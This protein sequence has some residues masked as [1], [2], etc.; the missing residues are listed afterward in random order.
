MAGALTV[1]EL[2][3]RY[4]FKADPDPIKRMDAAV[5]KLK[6]GVGLLDRGVRRAFS[7]VATAS[8]V[9]VAAFGA[10]AVKMVGDMDQVA[11]TSKRLGVSSQF[12][13]GMAHAAEL[14]GASVGELTTSL[15]RISAAAND[16]ASGSKTTKEAFEEIGVSVKDASGNLKPME[17]LTLETLEGL[18][19]LTDKTKQAALAQR[20]FGRTGQAMLPSLSQGADGI[21]EMINEAERLGIVVDDKALKSS[22][23]L[24][25]S[26]TR[27]KGS[28]RGVVARVVGGLT[29]VIEKL[30]VRLQDWFRANEKAIG[31]NVERGIKLI[32]AGFEKL[33]AVLS[34]AIDHWET[35]ATVAAALVAGRVLGG[36]VSM[37]SQIASMAGAFGGAI[38]GAGKLAGA[39]GKVGQIGMALG[40]GWTIGKVLDD[41]LGLSDKLAAGL[42]VLDQKLSGAR[43]ART[44]RH[45][46][47]TQERQLEQTRTRLRE[48]RA[49]GVKSVATRGGGRVA[50][51]DEGIA[52]LMLQQRK[53]LGLAPSAAPAA[54]G[55]GGQVS[56]ASPQ[57][58]V[59]VPA[60]TSATQA[61]R[62]A[63]AAGAA[64]TKA[65]R[66]AMGDVAR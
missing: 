45:A 1:R 53:N 21:V 46:R 16:A 22:E 31:K 64:T 37:T 8:A 30:V 44:E 32:V 63:V 56:V 6:R 52:R 48:L 59:T 36:L 19:R 24:N 11:K 12:F 25:D 34:F 27:L 47:Q 50:L 41:A 38:G 65:M 18:S 2:I 49:R 26:I 55:G 40:V 42:F 57:I 35:L 5:D 9:G 23:D 61:Q 14:S 43:E 62:V 20:L 15:R 33:G 4:T 13:Q 54:A 28:I 7:A 66:A 17:L 58:N 3:T 60:G 10:A 29:P 39:L 51:D